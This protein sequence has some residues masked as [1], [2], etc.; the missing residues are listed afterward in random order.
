VRSE[1][2]Q[3]RLAAQRILMITAHP[4]HRRSV[5]LVA[6]FALH[7][8]GAALFELDLHVR[9]PRD[10]STCRTPRTADFFPKRVK[11]VNR[12]HDNTSM[13]RPDSMTLSSAVT[14]DVVRAHPRRWC[15][16]HDE[17]HHGAVPL[18]LA[19]PTSGSTLL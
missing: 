2:K 5:D 10:V 1:E 9:Q 15:R 17:A 14:P 18:G 11:A 12:F 8:A 7:L 13:R 19:M 4:R 6:T 3:V 16:T